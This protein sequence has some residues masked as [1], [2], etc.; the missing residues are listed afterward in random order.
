[1][2]RGKRSLIKS[3]MMCLALTAVLGSATACLVQNHTEPLIEY[4]AEA[5][6]GDTVWSLCKR[7]VTNKDNLQ[8]VVWRT[9]EENHIQ[10]PTELQPGQVVVVHVKEIHQEARHEAK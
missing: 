5:Q 1:M 8:E 7:I 4:R 10:D 2:R 6:S 9:I 3:G